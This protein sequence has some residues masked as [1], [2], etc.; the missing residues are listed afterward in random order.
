VN[1]LFSGNAG[2]PA[3]VEL[4]LSS[5]VVPVLRDGIERQDIDGEAVV[6]S[7]ISL[8]PTRLDPVATVL[9]DV[10]DGVASIG[11]IVAD[12]QEVIGLPY[13]VAQQQ[14]THIVRTFDNA[15]LLTTSSSNEHADEAIARRELFVAPPNP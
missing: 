14:V 4:L 12:V 15:K 13:D 5:D 8:V 2:P 10:I 3:N 6:W 9:L 11:E 7:P 1:S